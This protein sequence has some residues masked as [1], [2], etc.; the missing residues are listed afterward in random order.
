VSFEPSETDLEEYVDICEREGWTMNL[1]LAV[2]LFDEGYFNSI[3]N[4]LEAIAELVCVE[5]HDSFDLKTILELKNNK[6]SPLLANEYIRVKDKHNFSQLVLFSSSAGISMADLELFDGYPVNYMERYHLICSG[7]SFDT[8]KKLIPRMSGIDISFSFN[9]F[10]NK[11]GNLFNNQY[12]LEQAFVEKV[13]SYDA[14]FDNLS[15]FFAKDYEPDVVNKFP[16]F[17]KGDEMRRLVEAGCTPEQANEYNVLDGDELAALFC[18]GLDESEASSYRPYLLSILSKDSVLKGYVS[19]L[20]VLLSYVGISSEQCPNYINKENVEIW[21]DMASYN[22]PSIFD[23]LG[24]SLM[25][26]T[27][28]DGVVV[29]VHNYGLNEFEDPHFDISEDVEHVLKF[30]KNSEHEFAILNQIFSSLDKPCNCIRP[31]RVLEDHYAFKL[32]SIKGKPLS[33]FVT[34]LN[35]SSSEIIDY[36]FQLLNGLMQMRSAEVYYHRDIRPANVLVEDNTNRVVII[37]FG[38]ASTDPDAL[39]KD[40]RRYGVKSG[41][42]ANDLVSLGQIMYKMATGEHLFL[43]SKSMER[44]TYADAIRDYRD[45]VLSDFKLTDLHL[46]KIDDNVKDE[47]LRTLIKSCIL[48][49]S[50]DYSIVHAMFKRYKK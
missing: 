8:F 41:E 42:V 19:Y 21:L 6:I 15:H 26:G 12:E 27:G 5:Y 47:R 34:E 10:K 14:R 39:A 7:L 24:D 36:S 30:S 23:E 48:S 11:K 20:S 31:F 3:E 37:D 46:N 43:E 44:T 4:D 17:C 35:L 2:S 29:L 49:Q 32:E 9:F 50:E 45:I 28:M 38:I 25:L 33:S 1:E 22:M 18:A 16:I 13:F 40:N